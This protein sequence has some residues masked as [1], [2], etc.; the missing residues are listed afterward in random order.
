[1]KF[2]S[3]LF[4]L[5]F[6]SSCEYTTISKSLCE[7]NLRDIRGF[8]GRYTWNV[9]GQIVPLQIRRISRGHYK[10]S[11]DGGSQGM[12]Y[13][14]CKINGVNIVEFYEEGVIQL[15][16]AQFSPKKLDIKSIMFNP[17]RLDDEGIVYSLE[18]GEIEGVPV[19]L[20]EVDN[21]HISSS[22][23]ISLESTDGNSV[24]YQITLDRR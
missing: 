8:A 11:G 23:L 18:S 4:L 19:K 6:V 16:K 2:L 7:G 3:S 22:K 10:M 15:L 17:A 21:K 12:E 20:I 14:T 9:E 1:M 13:K 5:F 24:P